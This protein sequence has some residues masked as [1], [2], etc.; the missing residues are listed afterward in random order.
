M[1][2]DCPIVIIGLLYILKARPLLIG[3]G[4]NYEH[5]NFFP[6]GAARQ[7]LTNLCSNNL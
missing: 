6:G 3:V 2:W 7:M 5:L 1:S 4:I